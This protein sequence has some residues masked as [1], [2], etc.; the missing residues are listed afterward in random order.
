MRIT[1]NTVLHH[2]QRY[3]TCGDWQFD[4]QGNLTIFVSETG[5]EWMNFLVARHELDEAM[6][7]RFRKVSQEQVDEYD[8]S[9]PDA[10]GDCFSANVDAPY[11][12]SHCDALCAEWVMAQLVKV[13]WKHYTQVIEEIT[14]ETSYAGR[15][16][17]D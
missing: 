16:S 12:Q 9:H 6:L 10:G 17:S 7:C 1:I 15:N 14:D 8:L 4:D 11:Y 3:N 5:N 2:N 13:D